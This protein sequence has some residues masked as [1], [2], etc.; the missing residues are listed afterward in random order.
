MTTYRIIVNTGTPDGAGTDAKS[1]PHSLETMA[2][3]GKGNW[4]TGVTTLKEAKL[5]CSASTSRILETSRVSAFAMT[6]LGISLDGS[7]IESRSSTT[8]RIRGGH[9]HVIDGLLLMRTTVRLIGPFLQLYKISHSLLRPF[10]KMQLRAS[11]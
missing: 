2:A 10:S 1:I 5:M 6:T 8:Q 7:W 3:A 4:T 11:I 9:S